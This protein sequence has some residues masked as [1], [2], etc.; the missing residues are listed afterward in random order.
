MNTGLEKLTEA[1]ESVN[2]MSQE[3]VF[4]EKDLEM[5]NKKAEDVLAQ[6][7]IQANAAQQVKTKVQVVKVRAVGFRE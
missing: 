3:L 6:V 2:K 7:T 1:T 4:V 5:A